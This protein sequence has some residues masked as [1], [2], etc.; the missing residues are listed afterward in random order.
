M[1][2]INW[3][4]RYGAALLVGLLGGNVL[5][6]QERSS[7]N[8]PVG[9]T[10]VSQ[11][12]FDLHMLILWICVV[13]AVVVF[14]A[15]IYCMVKFRKSQGAVPSGPSHSTLAEIIWT[16]IPVLILV[17]MAVPAART[18]VE[19]EDTRDTEMTVKI[20]GYQWKWH[21]EYLDEDVGFF[22]SLAADSNAARQLGS[23]IDPATVENYL[24][25]VDNPLVVPTN[26]RIRYLI[27][28]ND[29]LHAWWMPDFAVK[30]DAIPG[31]I[32]EGWFEVNEPGVYR[33][34]C[35]E[36]CGKDHGF[37]P[38]VVEALPPADYRAWLASQKGAI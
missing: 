3:L 23:S 32:N 9:V 8:M 27:T 35:A 7:L 5:Q 10:D 15:M 38:I 12:V 11:K 14:T 6:A 4:S 16:V 33:G 2:K 25:D 26:T 37:M 28:S 29:V 19:I 1:Q 24:L 22:S 21:Y 20:T 30:K 13:I 31:F 34:Q 18:L 17:S 36:L